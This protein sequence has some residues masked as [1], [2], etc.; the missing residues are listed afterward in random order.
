MVDYIGDADNIH[1][2][3]IHY[4]SGGD[5]YEYS[6]SHPIGTLPENKQIKD[7]YENSHIAVLNA[8]GYIPFLIEW[9]EDG[10]MKEEELIFKSE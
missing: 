6:I 8:L 4:R 2:I 3:I 7:E 1:S 5:P 9:S 10:N